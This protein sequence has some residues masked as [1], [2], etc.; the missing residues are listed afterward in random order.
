MTKTITET[1]SKLSP[2]DYQAESDSM[3]ARL[4]NDPLKPTTRILLRV[5]RHLGVRPWFYEVGQERNDIASADSSNKRSRS[6]VWGCFQ[7]TFNGL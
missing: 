4:H 1:A 6:A 3:D 2:Q 5:L 7:R